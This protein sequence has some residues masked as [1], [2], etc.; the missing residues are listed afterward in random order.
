[1]LL[2]HR[3]G[4]DC[5][6]RRHRWNLG[7]RHSILISQ[8]E[9]IRLVGRHDAITTWRIATSRTGQATHRADMAD[10]EPAG[11][12]VR[13][14]RA[15]WLS[16]VSRLFAFLQA[17]GDVA[18]GRAGGHRLAGS[19]PVRARPSRWSAPPGGSRGSCLRPRS[20]R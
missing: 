16:I 4:D 20:M 15:A 2:I 19:R 10:G 3:G 14:D 8:A 9:L 6:A 7:E 5:G 1:M 18:S 11:L 12:G 17:R 13:R